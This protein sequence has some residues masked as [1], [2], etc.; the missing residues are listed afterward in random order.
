MSFKIE[1]MC[2]YWPTGYSVIDIMLG[3]NKR[4]LHGNMTDLVRGFE[5]NGKQYAIAAQQ[6]AGKSTAIGEFTSFP[7]H[8]AIGMRDCIHKII[9][10]DTDNA[11]WDMHRIRKLTNLDENVI[12]DKYKVVTTSDIGEITDILKKESEEYVKLKLKPVK[13]VDPYM[14]EERVM[15]PAVMIVVDTVTSISSDI[16][17]KDIL[18]KQQSLTT[19]LD[20]SNLSNNIST[21]FGGN[22]VTIWM[23]HLKD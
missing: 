9:I 22:N 7:L 8:E 6:G 18:A 11:A 17:E 21:L 16:Y 10:I 15:M 13:F 1:K 20:V 4:D 14:G 3:E 2:H 23:A 5:T 12:K 19:F